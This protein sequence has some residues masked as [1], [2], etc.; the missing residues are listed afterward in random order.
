MFYRTVLA[1]AAA[2][3]LPA[4]GTLEDARVAGEQNLDVCPNIFALGDAARFVEFTGDPATETV[5]WT[6]EIV[7]VRTSCRY[8]ADRPIEARVEVDFAIGRGPAASDDSFDMPFFVAVTRK[9]R[10]VIAKEEFAVPV[11]VRRGL[12]TVTFTEKVNEITIPRADPDTSGSNFEIAVGFALTRE[13]LL[14]NRS[15]Q[16]LKFPEL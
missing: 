11:T 1:L 16:S 13:Q 5:A 4:C 14:Y 6:G 10:A 12:G 3:V 7:D 8:V 2:A 9:N 15:G